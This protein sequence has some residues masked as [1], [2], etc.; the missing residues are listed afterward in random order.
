M[1]LPLLQTTTLLAILTL[2]IARGSNVFKCCSREYY[3]NT[4][5]SKCEKSEFNIHDGGGGDAGH[6]YPIVP[7]LK[8]HRY[9]ESEGISEKDDF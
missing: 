1:G 2:A 4:E 9:N 6:E 7:R 8:A 5:A 3:Y